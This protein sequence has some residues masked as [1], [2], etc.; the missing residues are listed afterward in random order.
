MLCNGT[1]MCPLKVGNGV[2]F[3]LSRSLLKSNVNENK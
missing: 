3:Q 1:F 2:E